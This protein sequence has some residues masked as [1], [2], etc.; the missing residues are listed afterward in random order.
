MGTKTFEIS[1]VLI[2]KKGDNIRVITCR[3]V[4]V[5]ESLSCVTQCLCLLIDFFMQISK[6]NAFMFKTLLLSVFAIKK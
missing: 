1:K 3:I 4:P 2:K 6:W 5:H